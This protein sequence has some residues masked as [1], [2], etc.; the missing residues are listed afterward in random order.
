MAEH[1]PL[2]PAIQLFLSPLIQP[3]PPE[4]AYVVGN[5]IKSCVEIKVNIVLIYQAATP[6]DCI[7]QTIFPLAES[8]LTTPVNF[9][10]F[11]MV[12]DSQNEQLF[13]PFTRD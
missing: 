11:G 12:S 8:R 3:A 1:H 4:F 7:G 6:G 2:G 9:L 10:F 13:H 5:S